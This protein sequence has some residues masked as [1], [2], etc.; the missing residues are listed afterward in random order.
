MNPCEECE[1]EEECEGSCPALE[2]WIGQ[3][4]TECRYPEEDPAVWMSEV[5]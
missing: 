4:R 1:F 3:G 5:I 2:E